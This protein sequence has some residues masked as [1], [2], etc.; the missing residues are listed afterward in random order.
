MKLLTWYGTIVRTARGGGARVHAPL[1]PLRDCGDDFEIDAPWD[2]TDG[3]HI[4][5][6]DPPTVLQSAPAGRGLHIAQDNKYLSVQ[7]DRGE[8]GFVRDTPRPT[9]IFLPLTAA[10]IGRLRDIIGH[11]WQIVETGATVAPGEVTVLDAF[12][13][14]LGRER[15]SLQA[16]VPMLDVSGQ[17]LM[18]TAVNGNSLNARRGAARPPRD[19]MAL[20]PHAPGPPEV[21]DAAA[22]AHAAQGSLTLRGKT[23]YGFLPL[24]ARLSHQGWMHRRTW[25]AEGPTLGPYHA[26]TRVVRE[27]DKYVMLTAGQEGVVFDEAGVTNEGGYLLNQWVNHCGMMM[28]EGDRLFLDRAVLAAAPRLAGCHAIFANGNL[29][30]YY[31]WVIDAL[32]PLFIMR[33]FLPPGTRLLIPS[34]IADLRRVHGIVDHMQALREWGFGDIDSVEMPPPVCRVEE[35][36]WVDQTSSVNILAESLVAAR[37]HVWSRVGRGG[38]GGRRIYVRR[39]GSRALRNGA[40]VE[41][42]LAEFGFETSEMEAF[43]PRAQIEMFRDAAYVVAVHG[44]ALGNIMFCAPGTRV[45]E[46][47]PDA[48]YRSCYAE[49][50]DKLGLV[51]AML[52]CAALDNDFFGGINVDVSDLRAL[53]TQLQSWR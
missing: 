13:L 37:A 36:V 1:W 30:N 7:P 18:M 49:L 45:L 11:G 22:F 27:R 29:S 20:L 4:L 15:I 3:R 42:V 28:R 26:K 23:E 25:R 5:P 2:R 39:H 8:V 33:D 40:E 6:G 38:G 24:T 35:V 12:V 41:S 19:E 52:P 44:A 50:S 14:A 31:H 46:I 32:L 53:L 10:E 51:H 17:I 43:S 16:G 48:E 47:S 34:R 21:A 9:E